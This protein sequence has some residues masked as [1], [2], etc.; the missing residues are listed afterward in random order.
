MAS[1]LVPH[2]RGLVS[3]SGGLVTP[4]FAPHSRVFAGTFFPPASLPLPL[5]RPRPMVPPRSR[6]FSG[7]GRGF[8]GVAPDGSHISMKLSRAVF[9][10]YLRHFRPH[11]PYP[12]R[13]L[14]RC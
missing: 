9:L 8:H 12:R 14:L 5:C 13:L 10:G 11:L 7:R 1:L 3:H 4:N 2:Y 6:L